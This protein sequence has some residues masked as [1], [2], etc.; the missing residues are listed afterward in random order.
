[1]HSPPRFCPE[2]VNPS[3][4]GCCENKHLLPIA[5]LYL[6]YDNSS[7]I[8]TFRRNRYMESQSITEKIFPSYY[9]IEIRVLKAFRNRRLRL[10]NECQEI[11]V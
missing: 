2:S 1:M 6:F 7:S 3:R 8:F 10:C 11:C 9:P 5:A 4:K